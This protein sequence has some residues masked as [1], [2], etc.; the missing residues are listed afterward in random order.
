MAMEEGLQVRQLQA[1]LLYDNQEITETTTEK[2]EQFCKNV[3]WAA[4][5]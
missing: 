2:M 3:D 1:S 5:M 4:T